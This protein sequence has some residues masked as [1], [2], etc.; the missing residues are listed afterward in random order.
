MK[1]LFNK[2]GMAFI[3]YHIDW[4]LCKYYIEKNLMLST[5]QPPS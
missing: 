2:L 5:S 1:K 4:E 3:L